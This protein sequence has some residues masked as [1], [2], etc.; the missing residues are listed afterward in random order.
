MVLVN[1]VRVLI[2]LGRTEAEAVA[3]LNSIS[4]AERE[5]PP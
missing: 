2:E 5:P 3:A 1:Y 4:E